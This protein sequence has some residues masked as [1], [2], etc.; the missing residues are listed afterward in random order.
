LQIAKRLVLKGLV[1]SREQLSMLFVLGEYQF[2]KTYRYAGVDLIRLEQCFGRENM[3]R[4]YFQI[5]AFEAMPLLSLQPEVFDLGPFSRFHTSSFESLWRTV[6]R[7]VGAQWRYENNL[8]D[9][10]GPVFDGSLSNS[11]TAP[12]E[13]PKGNIQALCFSGGGKDSLVAMKL[14]ERGGVPLSSYAYSHPVYGEADPQHDL[15]DGSLHTASPLRRHKLRIS[16]DF[17]SAR[18]R[19]L[20]RECGVKTRL[21][22]ETPTAVLGSLP[23]AL[24]YGYRYLVVGHEHS[25]DVGNLYWDQ[26]GE[27]VNHQWAKSLEAEVLLSGYIQKELANV[28]YFSVLK[29]IHDVLIF[30]LLRR[31]IA[32]VNSTH[33]CN[34]RK[35]WCQQ[36]A[37]CAYVWL[38]YT[39]YL[40]QSLVTDM[41]PRNLFDVPENV[42]WFRQLM[43]LSAHKPFEC[44]GETSEVQLAFEI[45]RRRGF[46]GRAIDMY[47]NEIPTPDVPALLDRYLAVND[48]VPTMPADIHERV[49]PQMLCAADQA[50]AYILSHCPKAGYFRAEQTKIFQLSKSVPSKVFI[51]STR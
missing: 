35:P 15:I 42:N 39:A 48:A 11:I 51:E 46:R 16:D 1:R 13:I 44:V 32:A 25:A 31:D 43:G 7:K 24:Q 22:V 40:P 30:N 29:P 4:I 38:G 37:K 17:S 26:T 9:Y 27:Y 20:E 14:L 49:I 50:R 3:E 5:A 6:F 28:L 10:Q 23:V 2:T 45:C 19:A 33:S 36:C 41:F 8:P 12:I 47:A 18:G 21:C 34:Q